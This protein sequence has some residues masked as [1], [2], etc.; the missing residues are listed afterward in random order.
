[1]R[2]SDRAAPVFGRPRAPRGTAWSLQ[3]AV[4][5]PNQ[6]QEI[7]IVNLIL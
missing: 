4:Q 5:H 7:V 6:N 2:S 3:I 1:M